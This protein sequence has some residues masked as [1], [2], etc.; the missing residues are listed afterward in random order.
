MIAINLLDLVPAFQRHLRQYVR[1]Q[2]TDSTLAAYLADAIQA[3]E[4]RWARDYVITTSQ[5]NS[6]S[7]SPDLATKD[8]RP[9]ILMASI[10]YK[11]GT[12]SLASYRDGDF[13]FDPVQGK[14]N[15]IVLDIEELGKML[16][17]GNNLA[18]AVTAPMRGYAAWYN[19]ETYNFFRRI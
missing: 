2:D 9:I 5:P 7:V 4:W 11:T 19:P 13:A 16:P 18:L 12:T 8:Y 17:V 15:P 3:L 14:T 10:I 6:Y 1:S